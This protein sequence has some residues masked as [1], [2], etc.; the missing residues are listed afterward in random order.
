MQNFLQKVLDN[1]DGMVYNGLIKRKG[2]TTM[3]NTTIFNALTNGYNAL[4]YTH[5]YIF[6]FEYKHNVYMV[7]ATA[8]VLPYVLTLDKAS[9][10][11]GY[12]LRFKP[13][14]DQKL[15]LMQ[16]AEVLCSSEFFASAVAESKYN[17]GEIFEKM[18]TEKF[19]QVWVKDNV[20]FTEDG[21][22]TVDGIAYQIKFQKA[23]FTNEKSLARLQAA[24]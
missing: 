11:A 20:P 17:A 18:V 22:L 21:D 14:T 2:N 16:G 13:T 8:E 4:S 5:N 10:G 1:P 7:K 23:T 19:G 24:A 3:T 9:R 6:G 15:F 12:A